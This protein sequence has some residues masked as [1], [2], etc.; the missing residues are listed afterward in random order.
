MTDFPPGFVADL[1]RLR[2]WP[3]LAGS[4][5]R[6]PILVELTHGR[7]WRLVA[8]VL[9]SRPGRVLDIGCGTG[10]LSLAVAQ[11]GHDVTAI[12]PD[13]SALELAERSAHE[14]RPGRL[15]YHRGDVATWVA[16]EAGFDVVVASRTLHHVRQPAA[17]LDRVRRW[18]RPGGQLVCIDFFH[19]RFDRRDAR[20]I[21]QLR[22]LLEAV[23][24]YSPDGRLPADPAAAVERVEWEW[25]QDHVV[26]QDLNSSADIEAPLGHAFP[27]NIRSWHPYL[28]WDILEA[29]DVSDPTIEKA[30][31]TLVADWEESL[32]AAGE[33]TPVL[34]RFVGRRDPANR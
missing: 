28:Y 31:A 22:G 1:R 11:A 27:T 7:L 29:L 18:L 8:E 30:T 13:P 17:A 23:G 34:L 2:H 10:A 20:W 33:L 9:P 32:L 21:A 16:D 15:A 6:S 14:A 12:D 19:D 3:E 26:E 4:L 25:E 24:A 5:W